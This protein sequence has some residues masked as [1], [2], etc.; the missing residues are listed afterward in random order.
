MQA[1]FTSKAVILCG[2]L[3]FIKHRDETEDR[4]PNQSFLP[5]KHLYDENNQITFKGRS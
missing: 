3:K 4:I 2:I 5:L 1:F